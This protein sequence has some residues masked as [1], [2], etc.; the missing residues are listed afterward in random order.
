M[1]DQDDWN[2]IREAKLHQ[3]WIRR[4]VRLGVICLAMPIIIF[5]LYLLSR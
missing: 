3:Q 4:E 1:D 5:I 2:D